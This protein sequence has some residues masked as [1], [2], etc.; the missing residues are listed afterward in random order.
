MAP[1]PLL[2]SLGQP[3][4]GQAG[5][6]RFIAAVLPDVL[7]IQSCMGEQFHHPEHSNSHYTDGT[8]AEAPLSLPLL[9]LPQLALP[10]LSLLGA[11]ATKQSPEAG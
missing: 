11:V 6:V 4:R 8:P 9:S 5:P 1:T 7:S 2:S 10:L 3:G